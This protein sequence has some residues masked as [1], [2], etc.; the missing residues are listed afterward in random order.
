M[1]LDTAIFLLVTHAIV[2]ICG[3]RCER[4]AS[5]IKREAPMSAKPFMSHRI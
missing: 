3:R 2:F 1:T 5:Q 4:A